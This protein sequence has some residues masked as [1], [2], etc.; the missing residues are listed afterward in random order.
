M[1]A[2]HPVPDPLLAEKHA[3]A[4]ALLRA[5]NLDVWLT[6]TQEMGEGGDP[7]YPLLMGARDLGLGLLLLT[8]SGER[9]AVVG[10]L[11]AALPAST[12]AWDTVIIHQGRASLAQLLREQLARLD[13]ASIAL[14]Y[15]AGNTMADGLS[16]GK[17]LWL[18]EALTGT[19]YLNRLCSSERV[20]A[21]LRALKSPEEVARISAAIGAAGEVLAALHTWLRPGRTGAEIHRY[22]L[23]ETARRGWQP[24]WSPDHCPVITIG[25]VAAMGHTPPGAEALLPGQVMQF[26]FGVRRDG[27]CSDLQRMW[28]CPRPGETDAPPE[29]RRLFETVQRGIRA[30]AAELKPGT[31]SWRPA[32]SAHKVMVDAGYPEPPYGV[33]H[34][35]GRAT[36][37]GGVGLIRRLDPGQPEEYLEAGSVYTVEGLETRVEGAGWV[38]QEEDVLLTPDGPQMLSRPQEGFWLVGSRQEIRVLPE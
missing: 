24:A 4:L 37:D 11:D 21:Q 19:P 25:P 6:F 22:V 18:Q 27:Y 28:Y 38:S 15:S 30:A 29:L 33:G 8:R 12:G 9:I 36:H 35:L 31:P 32:A 5:T 16:H 3:Q 34:Q 26:D 13:P 2:P 7:A 23:D 1:P 14:N 17:W 20:V 10:S